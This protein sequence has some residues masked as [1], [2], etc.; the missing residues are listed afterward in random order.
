MILSAS[1]LR[2]W[3]WERNVITPEVAK[4]RYRAYWICST[5][6]HTW[7]TRVIR[8]TCKDSRGC[9]ACA[10]FVV[11]DKNRLS[12]RLPDLTREWDA[13]KNGR[14]ANSVSFGSSYNAWWK[15]GKCGYSWQDTVN[16]RSSGIGCSACSGHTVTDKNR[17][18]VL[19]PD[20]A[21]EWDVEKNDKEA[22]A[23]S[24]GSGYRAWW[25]CRTCNYEWQ[26]RVDTRKDQGCPACSWVS[27]ET[28]MTTVCPNL[29]NEWIADR[30]TDIRFIAY[31]SN[32]RA[33]WRCS[34]CNY[35]WQ[36]SVAH[37][38]SGSGC[39]ACALYG[40]RPTKPGHFYIQKISTDPA[41][42]KFGITNNKPLFRLKQ[43]QA[44]SKFTHTLLHDFSF[45]DG[46]T[47]LEIEKAVKSHFRDCGLGVARQLGLDFDGS[48]ETLP[49]QC[50]AELLV[51]KEL[52]SCKSVT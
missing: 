44:S 14:E 19:R 29:V 41:I 52:V 21:A 6:G 25:K 7:Q 23:V 30:N 10:G 20:L 1:V 8:R 24:I 12:L 3:D 4:S 40:Y 43:Q 39:P 18:T 38:A 27:Y 5:C 42:L 36:T 49:E 9:P 15:C 50:L 28:R 47:P 17:L 13:E 2:D 11:S 48:T 22:S 34:K 33:W 35:E 26:S 16:K 51:I 31:G 46:A 45:D 37:R 32:Y